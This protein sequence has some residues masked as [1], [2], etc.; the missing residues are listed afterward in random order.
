MSTPALHDGDVHVWR[1]SL[2][3]PSRSYWPLLSVGEQERASAYRN[4]DDRAKYV[5]A[6]GIMR[7]ILS[8][9]VD[10][11]AH[12]LRFT[13]G[14]FGK[15]SLE[16]ANGLEFNLTHSGAVGMLAVARGRA[17]GIDIVQ[18]DADTD[19]RGIASRMF[20]PEEQRALDAN[21]N[22]G[23]AFHEAW[24]RKEAWLKATGDGIQRGRGIAPP[25]AWDTV[26]LEAGKGYSAALVVAKPRGI[27]TVMTPR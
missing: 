6:H 25:D 1:F 3:E 17:V 18:H 27:I 4:D 12:E 15:P 22:Y 16:L 20:S 5:N 7:Q 2:I 8:S 11:A 14:T 19:H 10:L 9:Y 13:T 23:A 21:P 24:A 26:P